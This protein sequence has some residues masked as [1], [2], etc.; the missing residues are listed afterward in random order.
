MVLRQPV[1]N[2]RRKKVRGKA[3]NGAEA[4]HDNLAVEEWAL[5]YAVH[6]GKSDRLLACTFEAR[7][8]GMVELEPKGTA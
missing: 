8:G 1:V 3:I 6:E 5:F 4:A 7:L 2:R